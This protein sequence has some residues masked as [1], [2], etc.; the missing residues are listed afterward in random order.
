MPYTTSEIS[1]EGFDRVSQHLQ[2][3]VQAARSQ[4]NHKPSLPD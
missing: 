3:G 4:V 2:D 1:H